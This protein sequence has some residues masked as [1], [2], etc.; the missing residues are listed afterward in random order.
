MTDA[1][2]DARPEPSRLLRWLVLFAISLAM[3]GNYYVFDAL[4]PVSVLLRDQL[5]Y[6][7]EQYGL[8]FSAYNLGAFL[9]LLAAGPVIDRLG[10]KRAMLLFGVVTAVAGGLSALSPR[11]E[12]MRLSRL[13]LGV[14]A[15]PLIVAITTALARWFKGKELSFA[16]G[17]NLLVARL[18]SVAADN[19]PTWA[20]PL[21]GSWQ[22]PLWLG[23]AIG[24]TCIAGGAIY[25]LLERHAERRFRLGRMG[26]TDKLVLRDLVGFDRSYWYVVA[27]CLTFYSAI[28]PFRSFAFKF[29]T[30]GRG[31][32][33]ETAGAL[34]SLLP[35]MAMVA[36]PLFGLLVDKVGRRAL[37]MALGSLLL[38]PVY[39]VM[40]YT[41]VPLQITI[42]MMGISF[43]L[44]PAVLWPSVAYIVEERRLGTAYALMTLVQQVGWG[45]MNWLI[46]RA[47]DVAHASSANPAGYRPGMWIFSVLGFVGLAFSYLLW[48]TEKGP[49]AHGLETI[50]TGAVR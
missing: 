22:K 26:S 3:F 24:T 18:G 50:T 47:N 28:F 33:L 27:L 17:V 43:S 21:F 30:E 42:V 40:A 44:I 2:V 32:S 29:F 8:L 10:A 46:G 5:G 36:T 19:S 14:G 38:T 20:A 34:N 1:A 39:L 23:A 37:F 31:A 25:W 9:A 49:A 4:A 11:F 35:T 13:L 48:R 16:F 45:A 7:D 12:L 41:Q 15:E 6:S